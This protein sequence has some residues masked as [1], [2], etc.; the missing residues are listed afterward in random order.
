MIGLLASRRFAPSARSAAWW[1]AGLL[2]TLAIGLRHQV[3]GDW[4]A[5]IGYLERASSLT[6]QQILLQGD[7]G[8]YLLNWLVAGVGRRYLFR[9]P[10]LWCPVDEWN[11]GVRTQTAS[12]LAGA[13]GISALLGDCCGYGLHPASSGARFCVA[14]AGRSGGRPSAPVCKP[15][16]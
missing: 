4:F 6:F 5:Y 9:Q 3:G 14:R 2:L 16:Y 7:P 15:G 13:I 8:Y 11:L 1:L 12:A 10:G